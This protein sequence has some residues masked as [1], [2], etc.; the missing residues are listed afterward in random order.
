MTTLRLL[1][2]DLTGALNSAAPGIATSGSG[3]DWL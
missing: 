2:D 3:A 1:A